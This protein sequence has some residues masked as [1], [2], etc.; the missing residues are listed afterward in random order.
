MRQSEKDELESAVDVSSLSE[1]CSVLADI[2]REKSEH[3]LT[4]WQDKKLAKE[5]ERAANALDLT[6]AK[7][8]V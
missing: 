6:A 8:S 7:V 4:N 5:W 1:V 2:C 3:V